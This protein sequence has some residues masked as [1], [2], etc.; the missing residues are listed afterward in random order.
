MS[1]LRAAGQQGF[2]LIEL[3][4]VMGITISLVAIS[5]INFARPQT[6]T[7]FN[8]TVS[9]L[10]ADLKSQQLLAM[11]GDEGSTTT[12]QVQGI[13]FASASYTLFAGT[14]FSASDVNNYTVNSGKGVKIV[15]TL[16]GN[17]VRFDKGTGAVVGYVSGSDKITITTDE[18]TAILTINK[19]GAV[20]VN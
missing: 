15:T 12:Q 3:L 13:V 20:V 5:S 17:T 2:T 7:S 19:F 9:S 1:R 10:V 14:T 8:T 11:N 6:V 18:D 16:P 4:V